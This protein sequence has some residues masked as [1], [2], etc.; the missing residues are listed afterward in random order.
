MADQEMV[1]KDG[2][3]LVLPADMP[4]EQVRVAVQN[5]EDQIT[6]D[7]SMSEDPAETDD[8]GTYADKHVK[9][10]ARGGGGGAA[11]TLDF[12][13][14]TVA[15]GPRVAYNLWNN[16]PAFEG[17]GGSGIRDAYEANV[18]EQPRG[19][20]YET[21]AAISEVAVPA[22]AETFLTGSPKTA[23]LRAPRD[24]G[25]G[26]LGGWVGEEGAKRLAGEEYSDLGRTIGSMVA[27]GGASRTAARSMSGGLGWLTRP[28][29]KFGL[30][31]FKL[32]PASTPADVAK[33]AIVGGS[34]SQ[35]HDY[36]EKR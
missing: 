2:S 35:A 28:L 18:I 30:D 24:A 12:L 8:W 20:D 36:E 3:V 10:T 9:S 14:N 5:A 17:F 25:L 29:G 33:R 4:D 26:L 19:S 32:I 23:L 15:V 6:A 16:K 31:P 1:L 34:A 7:A 11:S 21:N 22:L 27:P 13:G